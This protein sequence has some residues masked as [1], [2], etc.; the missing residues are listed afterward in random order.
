MGTFSIILSLCII[1][2]LLFI[3]YRLG[4][5]EETKIKR[6]ELLIKENY[7][8]NVKFIRK[9][10]LLEDYYYIFQTKKGYYLV[11]E[12]GYISYFNSLKK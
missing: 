3:I 6:F 10:K 5:S 1:I 12:N 2:F 7:T 11:S 9:A 4:P 8:T